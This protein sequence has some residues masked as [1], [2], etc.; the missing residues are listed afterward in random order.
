MFLFSLGKASERLNNLPEVAHF[1]SSKAEVQTPPLCSFQKYP[2]SAFD[3]RALSKDL[4][5]E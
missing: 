5:H 1:V 3:M 4:L 2:L